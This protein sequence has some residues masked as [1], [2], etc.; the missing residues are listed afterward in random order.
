M[1]VVSFGETV[2][3]TVKN[4]SSYG[5]LPTPVKNGYSFIAW[6]DEEGNTIYSGSIVKSNTEK[7]TCVWTTTI[8]LT[9]H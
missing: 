7:L 2:A 9:A 1:E 5:Q 3:Y 8:T 6:K 4:G